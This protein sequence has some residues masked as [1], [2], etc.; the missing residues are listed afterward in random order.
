MTI[1][2]LAIVAL[3]LI[4]LAAF[5]RN[6]YLEQR[7]QD[8]T[9]KAAEVAREFAMEKCKASKYKDQCNR[10]QVYPPGDSMPIGYD[11][12]WSFTAKTS[13][14][15]PSDGFWYDIVVATSDYRSY[16]VHEYKDVNIE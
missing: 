12:A 10:L 2:L 16:Y 3:T 8:R 1:I 7:Y 11:E 4:I 13:I 5:W 14:N 6:T 15:E 9:T